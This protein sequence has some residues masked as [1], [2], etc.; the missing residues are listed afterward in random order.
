MFAGTGNKTTAGC[1][2]WRQREEQRR[3]VSGLMGRLTTGPLTSIRLSRRISRGSGPRNKGCVCSQSCCLVTYQG[4]RSKGKERR[5]L[6]PRLLPP[7]L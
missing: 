6:W 3:P 4:S 7:G 1:G 5:P 2:R